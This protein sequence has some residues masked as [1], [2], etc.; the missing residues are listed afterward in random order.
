MSNTAEPLSPGWLRSTQVASSARHCRS[1]AAASSALGKTQ[2][3]LQ[4]WNHV[5][6]ENLA[7]TP[8]LAPVEAAIVIEAQQR[9][10]ASRHDPLPA[11]KCTAVE[12]FR[13]SS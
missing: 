10:R 6:V 8:A 2:T 12:F 1:K 4:E 5:G 7:L 9:S 13:P 11:E 3:S